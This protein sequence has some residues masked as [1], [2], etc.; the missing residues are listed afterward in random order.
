MLT[1]K[2]ALIY[3]GY[4]G[5]CGRVADAVRRLDR[6]A[7][8]AVL[9]WQTPG[10]LERAGLTTAECLE[11]VWLVYPDGRRYRAAAAA[12]QTLRELGGLWRALSLLYAVPGIRQLEDAAYRWV[13]RNRYR[14]PGA[15]A[16]CAV[17]QTTDDRQQMTDHR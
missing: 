14:L 8:L 5:I 4:C 16:A 11:A 1:N 2:P 9:P 15:S 7:R 6:R 17:P 12:N 10:L 3:D 13:A